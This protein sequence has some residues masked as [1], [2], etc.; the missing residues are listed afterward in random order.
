MPHMDATFLII[1]LMLLTFGLIMLF[2]ASYAYAL[3]QYGSS[4]HYIQRQALF[5][6][7]G[8][9]GMLFI[10]CI[11]YHV[12]QKFVFWI[13]AGGIGLL[14]LVF[15]FPPVKGARRWINLGFFSFQP[16]EIVKFALILLF[17]Y[18]ISINYEK[19][20]TF[21][22]GILPFVIPLGLVC[23]L[24]FFEPHISGIALMISIAL[25]MMFVGGV[26]YRYYIGILVLAVAGVL[27]IITFGGIEYVEARLK[28]WL[29]PFSDPQG[30]T[31]QTVQSLLA[32]GS[33]GFTGLGLGNSRQKYLYLPEPQ[34]DFIFSIVCEEL[35][36]IGAMAVIILFILFVVRGFIIASRAPDK[37]GAMLAVGLTI[38]IGIQAVLNIA[39]VTNAV[40]N[41]GISL[42][43]FSYGGTA[44][45]MQLF[46]MGIVLSV[47]RR[48]AIMKQ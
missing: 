8:V 19:M 28:S 9:V 34:N 30:D 20:G 1:V 5:A 23:G 7:A 38:Q 22:Y 44:L 31:F 43:F 15:A 2:S 39:V 40:P 13:F 18:L 21:R 47:S 27:L 6:A 48:S 41:T 25:V 33:G 32:I 17:A 42:P 11:D 12:L 26:K 24:M 37:F 16:S 45:M 35:G 29:D 3:Y 10:S 46:Q 14:I 36:F 4:F